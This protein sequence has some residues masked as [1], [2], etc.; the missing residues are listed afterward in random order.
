MKLAI[1]APAYKRT[2]GHEGFY[3]ND[4][5][6]PGAETVLGLTRSADPDWAGWPIVNIYKT[7]PNF[8]KNMQDDLR[9][10]ESAQ[11][12]YRKAY[13]RTMGC[14]YINS[15]VIANKLFDAGV[16]LGVGTLSLFLQYI[17]N[18][19][20]KKGTLWHDVPVSGVVGQD[21]VDAITA[22]LLEHNGEQILYRSLDAAQSCYYLV[23]RAGFKALVAELR[24]NAPPQWRETFEWGWEVNRT[25]D[26]EEA[27]KQATEDN[28]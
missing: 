26:Y 28:P 18:C 22:M 27:L 4:P 8:P 7:Q 23:G 5:D 14:D 21:T 15:Q 6:D 16:N 24:T 10:Y 9:I 19:F 17:L 11:N 13:W 2:K 12:Y 20:N 3:S 25:A 1:F